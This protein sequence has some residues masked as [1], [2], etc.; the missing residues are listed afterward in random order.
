MGIGLYNPLTKLHVIGEGKFT[1]S[2]QVGTPGRSRCNTT[3]D[4]GKII[5]ASYCSATNIK[6]TAFL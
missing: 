5:V 3:G 2:V 6:S 1:D 4:V